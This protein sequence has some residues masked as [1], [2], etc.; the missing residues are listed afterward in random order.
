MKL[1]IQRVKGARLS[2]DGSLVSEIGY[3]LCIYVGV[4]QGDVESSASYLATKVSKLRIFSDE[5]GKMNRSVMDESGD[6]LVISQFTLL[7]DTEHGNRPSYSRAEA[8]ERAN[9]LYKLFG[10]ELAKCGVKCVKYGVF[11]ADMSIEQ[12]NDGPVT[13]MMEKRL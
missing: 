13:I 1:V 3:G 9:F 10:E 6:V 4:E 2:V 12:V 8:P 5:N 7:G 11:G